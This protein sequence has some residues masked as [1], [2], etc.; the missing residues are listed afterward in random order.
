[1]RVIFP[2]MMI[3]FG[4]L[5]V[6]FIV[7]NPD[8]AVTVTLGDQQYTTSLLIVI[9][10]SLTLGA[11]FVGIVALIEGWTIRLANHKARRRIQQLETENSFLRS[12]IRESESES[13]PRTKPTPPSPAQRPIPSAAP[14]YDPADPDLA[15]D[16]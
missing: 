1:M 10:V 4:I 9:V 3:V 12:E 6:G 13:P 14:V 8:Q 11:V 2:L 5:L 7:T 15:L 16:D